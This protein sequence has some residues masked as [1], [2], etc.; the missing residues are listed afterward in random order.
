MHLKVVS[1]SFEVQPIVE[2]H[3][4][5]KEKAAGKSGG[6]FFINNALSGALR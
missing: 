2:I 3:I 4:N 6:F 5:T 1:L